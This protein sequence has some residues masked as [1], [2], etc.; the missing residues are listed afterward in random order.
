MD[1][2]YP[3]IVNG[4]N[5]AVHTILDSFFVIIW[6]ILYMCLLLFIEHAETPNDEHW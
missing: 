3:F 2:W 4:E 1:N 5:V 6:I